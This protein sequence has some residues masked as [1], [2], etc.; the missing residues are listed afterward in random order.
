MAQ[1]PSVRCSWNHQ[2]PHSGATWRFCW[3]VF[4]SQQKRRTIFKVPSVTCYLQT[5]KNATTQAGCVAAT[6]KQPVGC[7]KQSTFQVHSDGSAP[8][9]Q[10]DWC[11]KQVDVDRKNLKKQTFVHQKIPRS[12]ILEHFF[13][14]FA[15]ERTPGICRSYPLCTQSPSTQRCSDGVSPPKNQ[16]FCQGL[17]PP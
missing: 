6:R 14:N 9:R 1:T 5:K 3:R 15:M 13:F 4:K 10:E 12:R 17:S 2:V 16:R 11:F 8:P 7:M